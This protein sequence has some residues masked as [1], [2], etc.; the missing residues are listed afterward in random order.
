MPPCTVPSAIS[1]SACATG[2]LADELALPVEDAGDVGEE[3]KPRRAEGAGDGAGE[4]V[5]VDV[6]GVAVGAGRDR[7]DHRDQLGL[8]HHVDDRAVDASS[9]R[10][11][12]RGRCPARCSKSGSFMV[13]VTRSAKTMLPSLPERPTALPPSALIAMTISLLIDPASTI[14]TT[15]T[16]CLSVTRRPARN[17][18][19]MPRRVEHL[20]D[21]RPA[22]M[23]HD[24]PHAGGLEERDVAGKGP[25]ELGV[26]H[27]VAAIL[28]HDD[29]AVV[30]QHV[31][32]R[33]RDQPR[34]RD[35]LGG[36]LVDPLVHGLSCGS[37]GRFL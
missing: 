19:L 35:R 20:A 25:G 4:S 27:G 24:R 18:D 29:L 3:E 30:A 5:G 1:A 13:R 22:A 15:S 14:S 21:L 37:R 10:R 6:V 16:V 26:A 9:A 7:R 2:E 32:Q 31:G 12:N 34:P 8:Q 23:H 36:F 11:R 28:H 17:S 33:R